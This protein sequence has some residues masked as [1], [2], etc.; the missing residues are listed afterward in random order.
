MLRRLMLSALALCALLAL[1]GCGTNRLM[2]PAVDI[3]KAP[4]GA[5]GVGER[6]GDGTDNGGLTD[7]Q[8]APAAASDSLYWGGELNQ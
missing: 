7:P 2:G 8:G 3:G 4:V 1:A 5:A 6:D